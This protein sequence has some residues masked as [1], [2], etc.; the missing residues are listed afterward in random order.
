MG[1]FQHYWS[2]PNKVNVTINGDYCGLI[3]LTADNIVK[4]FLD[5]D[6]INDENPPDLEDEFADL[7]WEHFHKN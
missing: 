7:V 4:N 3:D 6:V 5:P 1:L 2:D